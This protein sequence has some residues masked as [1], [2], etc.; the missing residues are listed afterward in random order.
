DEETGL[1]NAKARYF[2]PKLGRFLTQDSFLG[3]IDNPPSLHRYFYAN[4][5]PLRYVD[6]TGHENELAQEYRMHREEQTRQKE[7]AWC[8]SNPQACAAKSQAEAKASQVTESAGGHALGAGT[9][10]AAIIALLAATP[11]PTG[12]TKVLAGALA[13][14][15]ADEATTAVAELATKEARKSARQ[16]V[17]EE[18]LSAINPKDVEQRA[19]TLLAITDFFAVGAAMPAGGEP[20]GDP[21]ASG[22]VP[23]GVTP[24]TGTVS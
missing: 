7:V 24:R 17:T 22:R 1:Y 21:F 14:W 11:E 23:V 2:D 6:P 4:E 10:V 18:G 8:N 15:A 3:R 13:L 19:S 12:A 20:T 16:I 5:N 9:K